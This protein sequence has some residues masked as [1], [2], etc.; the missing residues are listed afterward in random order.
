MK[1]RKATANYETWLGQQI[2]LIAEDLDEKHEKMGKTAFE[3]LRATYYRWAQEWPRLCPETVDAP[4]V[5]AVGDL[6]VENFGTWRDAEGR[7]VWGVNDFDEASELPYTSDLVRL[8]ASARLAIAER[9]A[10]EAI[11]EGYRE[12]LEA[13]PKPLVLA[14]RNDALRRMAAENPK[15]PEKFWK[16]LEK[17]KT[18][19]T[20]PKD[21]AKALVEALPEKGLTYRVVHR[22]SGLGSLGRERYTAIAEW[23][24]GRLARE[25]KALA[26][27]A[28]QWATDRTGGEISYPKLLE[29][30]SRCPDPF[31]RVIGRWI[32][33]RLSPDCSRIELASLTEARDER[34]LL[35]A[36]GRETANVHLGSAPAEALQAD[37]HKRSDPWLH[38]AAKRMAEAVEE[39]F[40]D[41]RQRV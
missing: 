35:K 39:D 40:E 19:E 16:D 2:T 11:L 18:L 21:A 14:E 9:E 28:Q 31:V 1:I 38:Q 32:V 29:Q 10:P 33:R 4:A 36:M 3:F 5:L 20:V 7:Q 12:G 27:P 26:L 30:K 41:W 22:R 13:G 25:A 8:A 24:G 23:R 37:L 17:L 34:K 15:D 6:H